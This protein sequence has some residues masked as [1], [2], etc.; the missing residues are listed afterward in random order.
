MK[1]PY[2][3][4]CGEKKQY[5]TFKEAEVGLKGLRHNRGEK[6]LHIYSCNYCQKFHVGHKV[7][8]RRKHV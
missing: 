4:S 6:S 3:R 2:V 8:K 1:F 5:L 7:I